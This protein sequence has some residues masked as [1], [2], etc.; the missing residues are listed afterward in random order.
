MTVAKVCAEQEATMLNGTTTRFLNGFIDGWHRHLQ[1]KGR[2][3]SLS[4]KAPNVLP[5]GLSAIV[6]GSGGYHP[7]KSSND[8]CLMGIRP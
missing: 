6:G 1:A 2:A 5:I 8:D 4:P 7:A 3:N